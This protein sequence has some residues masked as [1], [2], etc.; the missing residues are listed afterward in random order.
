MIARLLPCLL[1][2]AVGAAEPTWKLALEENFDGAELNPKVWNIETGKRR[3]SL[4]S[5]KAVDLKDGILKI[6]TW[7]DADGT[8]YC[9]FVTTRKKFAVTQGKVAAR[10]RFGVQPGTQIAFWAQSPTYGKS[11]KAAGAAEDARVE[12]DADHLLE[13][14]RVPSGE[15][16]RGL[17]ELVDAL[18][19]GD[20]AQ[21][22]LDEGR[23]VGRGE[24]AELDDAV[25]IARQLAPTR[26]AREQ[27]GARAGED[28]ERRLRVGHEV[29]EELERLAVRLVEIVDREDRRLSARLRVP[30]GVELEER[31]H[32]RLREEFQALGA[33]LERAQQRRR[34]ELDAEDRPEEAQHVAHLAVVVDA[35]DRG[36]DL[37]AG[38]V[39]REAVDDPE[40]Y[41]QEAAEEAVRAI[42]GARAGRKKARAV[43]VGGLRAREHRLEQRGLPDARGAEDRQ[44]EAGARALLEQAIEVEELRAAAEE[45]VR[46]AGN[47]R[48]RRR[49]GRHEVPLAS[50]VSASAGE[51]ESI[52]IARALARGSSRCVSGPSDRAC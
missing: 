21:Q 17:D 2:A 29:R 8:T 24:R 37:R 27:I 10:C 18:A 38:L 45:V 28:D 51:R 11:G 41:A 40:A 15:R 16:A 50:A 31:A 47:R 48:E 44:A 26:E 20:R 3:D 52:R 49:C 43:V 5:P 1:L 6:T 25:P 35:L 46:Q 7:T 23:G 30:R 9:G 36:A 14:P 19:I 39:V 4:N 22:A 33:A 12:I 42:T 34:R 13:E 32:R